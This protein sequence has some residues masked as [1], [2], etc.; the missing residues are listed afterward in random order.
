MNSMPDSTFNLKMETMLRALAIDDEPVALEVIKNFSEKIIFL[1]LLGCFTDAFEAMDFLQKNEINVIFLDIK[2]PDISGLDFLK[3]ISNPPMIIFTTAYSEHAVQSFELN[4]IDY[5]LK[6]FSL[7]RFIKACNRANEQF[8]L[9]KKAQTVQ[10]SNPSIFVKSGYELIKIEL[11]DI[12]YVEGTGNYVKYVLKEQNIV[13][14]LTMKETE[15]LLPSLDFVRIH[16]S[17]L[18]GIK[19]ISRI[20]KSDI[21]IGTIEIPIG[22]AYKNKIGKLKS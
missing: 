5:L 13:T 15:D 3:S 11:D 10:E 20:Q 9:R 4:A 17:Y 6:P 22:E 12:L 8:E 1:D 16:R 21:W 2:M 14:R 18:V 7:S 19:H